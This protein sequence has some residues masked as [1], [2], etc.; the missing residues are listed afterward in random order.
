MK[1]IQ[2]MGMGQEATVTSNKQSDVRIGMIDYFDV[3]CY[4]AE[5]NFKWEEV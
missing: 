1:D 4:D 2:E 5:G 3:T